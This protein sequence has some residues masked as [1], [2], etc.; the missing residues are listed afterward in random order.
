MVEAFDRLFESIDVVVSP[1]VPVVAPTFEEA[2]AEPDRSGL[3]R[4]TRLFNLVGLP[5]CSVPCGFV[6]AGGSVR[7]PIGLQVVGRPFDESTVLRVASAY[8]R[9]ADW[10]TY[11]PVA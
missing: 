10:V 5:A 3:V 8:E 11:H 7:L 4:F 1:A 6:P 9:A 2:R